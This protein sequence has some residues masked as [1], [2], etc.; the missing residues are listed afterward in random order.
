M[1]VK[2]WKSRIIR[3]VAGGIGLIAF[4]VA[5]NFFCYRLRT[6]AGHVGDLLFDLMGFDAIIL[7]ISIRK[8][9]WFTLVVSI[10]LIAFILYLCGLG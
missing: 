4:N 3:D 8:R 10:L 6:F 1:S 9:M 2:P 5:T 7:L